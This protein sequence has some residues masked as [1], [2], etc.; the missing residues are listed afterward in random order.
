MKRLTQA[1]DFQKSR[2]DSQLDAITSETESREAK[3]ALSDDELGLVSA[4]GS[5]GVP[6]VNMEVI[7]G[8]H[9][10]SADV[11]EHRP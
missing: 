1:F 2:R 5:A 6:T 4:A 7:L 8:R 3:T 11:K 10:L 9:D